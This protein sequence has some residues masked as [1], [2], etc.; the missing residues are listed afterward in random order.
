MK[1]RQNQSRQTNRGRE[2][3]ILIKESDSLIPGIAAPHIEDI[4]EFAVKV[5]LIAKPHSSSL[6]ILSPCSVAVQALPKV[7]NGLGS[8]RRAFHSGFGGA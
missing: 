3:R 8:L 2:E 7:L 4:R 5:W 6:T 1:P